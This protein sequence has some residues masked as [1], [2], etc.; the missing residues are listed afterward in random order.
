M[1]GVHSNFETLLPVLEGTE[2]VQYLI[3][4]VESSI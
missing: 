3:K 1:C 4:A 2:K